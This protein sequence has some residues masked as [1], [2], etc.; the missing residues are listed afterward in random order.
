VK[1]AKMQKSEMCIYDFFA[2]SVW[3][4]GGGDLDFSSESWAFGY[5]KCVE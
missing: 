4:S 3:A 1:N 2:P 5:T